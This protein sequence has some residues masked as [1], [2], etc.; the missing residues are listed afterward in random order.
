MNFVP[1]SPDQRGRI[2]PPVLR[3]L[4]HLPTGNGPRIPI[5]P[6]TRL[7]DFQFGLQK[8]NEPWVLVDFTEFF[9]DWDQQSSYRWGVDRMDHSGFKTDNWRRMDDFI[10]KNPPIITFQRELLAK[11]VS[12]SLVPIEYLNYFDKIPVETREQFNQR[13]ISTLFSWGR[14]HESRAR[15]HADIFRQSSY[16]GYTVVSDWSHI[17]RQLE[18][19]GNGVWCAIHAPHFARID[20]RDTVRHFNRSKIVVAL[21]GAG[22]KTFRHGE[23]P[24]SI[25]A[26]P[27][28]RL[29][30]SIPLVHNVNC[31]RL[32]TGIGG[33]SIQHDRDAVEIGQLCDALASDRLYDIYREGV[34]AADALRP[35]SYIPDYVVSLIRS[36][37]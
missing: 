34:R 5:V 16:R 15:L 26:L 6:V 25:V 19:P 36:R 32:N 12:Q 31:I 28:D 14:S 10:L 8:F 29:A 17:D 21:N 20:V 27:E 37:L 35:V 7:E 22:V 23:I 13:P 4:K 11:D 33:E 1:I 3:I 18:E 9:W 2:D 30:W 24:N